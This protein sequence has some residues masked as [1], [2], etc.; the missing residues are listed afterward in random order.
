MILLF[1]RRAGTIKAGSVCVFI[2]KIGIVDPN[3]GTGFGVSNKDEIY[4]VNSSPVTALRHMV[5]SVDLVAEIYRV[6]SSPVTGIGHTIPTVD[7]VAFDPFF[8]KA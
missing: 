4:R 6:N 7:V 5:P 3:V 2:S 1:I 8:K